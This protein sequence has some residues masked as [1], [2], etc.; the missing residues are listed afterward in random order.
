ML[1]LARQRDGAGRIA[2]SQG[3]MGRTGL[4]TGMA[5][6]VTGGYALRNAA[7]LEKAIDE[8]Y[9]IMKP[10][11]FA[12]FLD[13]SKPDSARFQEFEY[14]LLKTWGGF[15][16]YVLH[17]NPEVYG[18]IAE[19]LRLYPDRLQLREIFFD[20]GFLPVTSRRYFFGITEMIVV[21][22]AR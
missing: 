15:W 5:D 9:R 6:V 4:E 1:A 10:G 7:D 11:G 20:K 3:D 17:R 13:F 22:K 19:S 12:A 18:Y 16:G 21:R 14:R 2:F 8:I